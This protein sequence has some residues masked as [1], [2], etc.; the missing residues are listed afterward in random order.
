MRMWANCWVVECKS[1]LCVV[2]PALLQL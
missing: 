2:S 1:R